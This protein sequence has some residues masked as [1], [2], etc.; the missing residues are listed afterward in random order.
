MQVCPLDFRYGRETM[1]IV[2]DEERRLQHMLDVEAALAAAHAKVGNISQEDARI[3]SEKASTDF[4]KLD[5]VW[6]IEKSTNHDI[7]AMV[8]AL[9]EQCGPSGDFVHLGAT[10]NDIVDTVMAM[11]FKNALAIIEDDLILLQ[12]AILDLAEKH[13]DTVMVG[14]THGQFAVPLT[15][16]MKMA[17]YAREIQRHIERLREA[18]PRIC[19]GKMSGA[20]GTGAA[21]GKHA[22]ELQIEI[23]A[24]LG[25]GI[26][27]ASLQLVG[28]DRYVEFVSLLA[29]ISSSLEKFAVEIRNLQR[30]EIGEVAEAFD[31]EKQVGSST[32]AHKRNPIKCENVCS[33]S[34]IVRGFII[35]T[36]E[37]VPLWHER[38]LTNS[39]AERF[40]IPHVSILV[41]D[42]LVKMSRVFAGLVVYPEKML[43]NIEASRGL[44]MAESVMMALVGKGIGRQEAHEMMRK[45]SL[46]AADAGAH[47]RNQM[48]ADEA[49]SQIFTPDEIDAIMDPKS[50][51]GQAAAI[52]ENTLKDLR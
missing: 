51:V 21:L 49:I 35:P 52:V 27:E 36:H 33:L 48:L 22:S 38:D 8:K 2:F 24:K 32:M 43:A 18:R 4:V 11:Q 7:M 46:K 29:N 10:S 39:A 13:R 15:F 23:M 5:R 50:Y 41:D 28:R 30:S 37:N 42:M 40:I 31:A 44:I 25:L 16:G 14:R 34:K 26:E 6:E 17:V 45:L 19:V 12:N 3:I 47:L 1:K 9:T 20:V